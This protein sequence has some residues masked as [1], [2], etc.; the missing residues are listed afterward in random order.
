MT[1]AQP[2]PRSWTIRP[3]RASDVATLVAFTLHEALEAEGRALVVADVE[4]GVS[5]AFATPPRSRY[6]VADEDGALIGSIS[7]VTEWS[8]F[9]GGDYWWVQSLYV[10]PECR[11]AGLVDALLDHL[12]R[13]AAGAG[14]LD[15]RLYAH[16]SNGRALRAYER[17]GF[18]RAPYALFTRAIHGA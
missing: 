16:E 9:H 15:L 8:N 14:A 13:E 4:R 10:V 3:A 1:R 5:A 2:A 17:A 7:A 6:W 11:G 18:S 12:A